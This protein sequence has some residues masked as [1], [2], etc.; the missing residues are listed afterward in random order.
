MA[1]CFQAEIDL[2]VKIISSDAKRTKKTIRT[3][4]DHLGVDIANIT[5]TSD[6]Y[7]ADADKLLTIIHKIPDQ[8]RRLLICG[9]NPGLT[10]CI[11]FITN[12][13]LVN[14]P[15]CALA[16]INAKIDHW[17]ELTEKSAQLIKILSPKSLINCEIDQ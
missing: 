10:D 16:I 9:H 7:M 6:L 11:N 5:L 15:T 8:T 14:L 4:A 1:H 2:P 12:A 13:N 17:S 3:V